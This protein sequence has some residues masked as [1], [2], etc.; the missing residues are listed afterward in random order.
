[1]AVKFDREN[2]AF[3]K[4]YNFTKTSQPPRDVWVMGMLM[5]SL[6]VAMF[7]ILVYVIRHA[8]VF[9]DRYQFAQLAYRH[10]LEA[11][12][13]MKTG[14]HTPRSSSVRSFW[15]NLTGMKNQ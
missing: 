10:H 1:M 14:N 9:Q 13:T 12:S 8:N 15:Y 5:S 7:A 4:H 6:Y 3:E 2:Y 11:A